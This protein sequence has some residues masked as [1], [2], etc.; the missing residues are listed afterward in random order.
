[1]TDLQVQDG[2]N[3]LITEVNEA[4][5]SSLGGG[6]T[7]AELAFTDVAMRYLASLDMTA[8]QVVCDYS[9]TVKGKDLRISGY[10]VGDNDGRLDL[11]IT[12]YQGTGDI[13]KVSIADIKQCLVQVTHFLGSS[14]DGTLEQTM[15]RSN[16]AYEL[17]STI[18]ASFDGL[19]DINVFVL[20]DAIFS[21]GRI[22]PINLGGKLVKVEV[23]DLQ[24][25]CNYLHGAR[26]HEEIVANFMEMYSDP[27]PCVYVTQKSYGYDY[28]ITAIPGEALRYL[29]ELYG[30][31]LLEANVR[32]FLSQT[33][34]VNKGIAET[35][36]QSPERFMAYNNGIVMV[37]EE[38]ILGEAAAG[39]PG[40]AVLRGIQIVNGGQTTASIYF[41]KRKHPE[42]D[43]SRVRVPTKIIVL[44]S[45][46]PVVEEALIADISRYSNSQNAVKQSD[47]SANHHFH[48]EMERLSKQ[49]LCPD[50]IGKWFYERASGS[51]STLLARQANTA[52]ELSRLRKVVYPKNR[53]VGKTD[54]AKY[55]A[56]WDQ[57]PYQAALGNQKNFERF[58]VSSVDQL[59]PDAA[60]FRKAIGI[61]ILHKRLQTVF[62]QEFQ[63]FQANIVAYTMA[64]LA[65][66][67]GDR[68][69][70]QKIWNSQG[71]SQKL[72]EQLIVWGRVVF[73]TLQRSANG[74][75]ISEWA[76]KPE[77]WEAVKAASFPAHDSSIPEIR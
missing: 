37:A 41:T 58:M 62:R 75:M 47:L 1:M 12:L 42:T 67:L 66:R 39:G 10:A 26:P 50:G 60:F 24:R 5:N 13:R 48:V 17:V 4:M 3:Q 7:F 14:I 59:I 51:Y 55:L 19:E 52:A 29:Y 6:H 15:D 68:V 30:E 65:N 38:L 71:I 43:I 53:V 11:F 40:I 20:T 56:I 2:L 28:A 73:E 25:L 49:V 18:R 57:K 33:G 72:E 8:D 76:K 22:K 64:V 54:M 16:E 23:V 77:C 61:A 9:A 74:R 21:N 34:K 35:L 45:Q 36:K 69:D 27:L 46:D 32:S 63:A 31:R 44:Q 70:F